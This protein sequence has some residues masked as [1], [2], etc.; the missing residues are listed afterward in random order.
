MRRTATLTPLVVLALTSGCLAGGRADNP[1]QGGPAGERTILIEVRNF[2]FADATI[3]AFRGT[4][5]IRLGTVTGKTDE[6]FR[7]EWTLSQPLRV[8][9][10]LLAG[11]RCT[12]RAMDVSPGAVIEV[13]VPIDL[14]RDPDCM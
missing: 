7:V 9:I 5:R 13:Q 14:A 8:Q 6:N 10:D 12:T 1:F 4:E 2:N 3:F 11:G